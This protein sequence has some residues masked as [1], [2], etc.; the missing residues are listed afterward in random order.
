VTAPTGVVS[1][2]DA[3]VGQPGA[4]A[5]L[6]RSAAAPVHAY[7]FVGPPGSTKNEAARAFA[8]TL[9]TGDVDRGNRDARLAM[10]GEHPDVREV[11]R[12]GP[13]ITAEQ[14][15]E[16]VRLAA[17]APVEGSRKVMILHEFHLLRPEGAALLLKTIEEP[18]A[19]TIFVIL[20]DF[21]P[22]DLVTIASRCVRIDF[23]AIPA[24]VLATRLTEE[25]IDAGEAARVA[26]AAG[27]DLTRARVLAADPELA[28]R[29]RAFAELPRALDGTG[30]TVVRLVEE[31]LARID[32]AAAPLAD[33]HSREVADLEATIELLGERGRGRRLLEERHKR[34]LRRHRTDELRNGLALLAASYRD[35]LVA[36]GGQRPESLIAAI[37]RIHDAI[38]AL[39]RNP[40]E[41]LLLQSLFWSLPAEP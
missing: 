22:H 37:E 30:A 36:G 34:E 23:R 10:A 31:L 8:A 2:W 32:D 19:S 16:I 21:I 14:A 39:E 11:E 20:A 41:V 1:V 38:E 3:V 40:N 28:E 13:F 17:L 7:L 18:P 5:A 6:R 9:L 24:D 26:A 35:T 4:V 15:R 29:R 33:Q 27:G 12:V 25:G